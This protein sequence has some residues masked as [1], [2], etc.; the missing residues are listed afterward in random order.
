MVTAFRHVYL[1]LRATKNDA[2]PQ[3]LTPFRIQKHGPENE[4]S[5]FTKTTKLCHTNKN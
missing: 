2:V 1:T 5:D 4:G 3:W